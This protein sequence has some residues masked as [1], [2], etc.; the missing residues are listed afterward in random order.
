MNGGKIPS[1]AFMTKHNPERLND[2]GGRMPRSRG[3]IEAESRQ[4]PEY[5]DFLEVL[6]KIE[7]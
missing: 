2:A 5:R 3:A 7:G 4:V 1:S 6:R